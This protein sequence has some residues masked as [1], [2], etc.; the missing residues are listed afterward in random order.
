MDVFAASFR[1]PHRSDDALAEVI[2]VRA[3]EA[4]ALDAAH[5][6]NGTQQIGEIVLAVEVRIDRLPQKHHFRNSVRNYRFCFTNHLRK[7][8]APFRAAGRRNDA[9][10]ALVVAA[11]LHGNPRLH[12]VK[13]AWSEILIVLLEVELDC[14]RLH[15]APR[16]L[17][18]RRQLAI[19]VRSD[20]EA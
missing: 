10:R 13:P 4:Q 15:A 5:A 17:D 18:Q 6:S 20:D 19:A 11:A 9:I 8:T 12:S 2:G 16:A 14:S 1:L 7:L 3:S